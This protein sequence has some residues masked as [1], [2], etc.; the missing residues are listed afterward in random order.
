MPIEAPPAKKRLRNMRF[1]VAVRP[2]DRR[3]SF[4]ADE[5]CC[6]IKKSRLPQSIHPHTKLPCIIAPLVFVEHENH[7]VQWDPCQNFA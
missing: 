3:S 2:L 7:I 4:F 6:V 1:Q 5:D